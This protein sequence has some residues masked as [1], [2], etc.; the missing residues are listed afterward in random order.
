MRLLMTPFFWIFAA[1]LWV[2]WA[3]GSAVLRD[4]KKIDAEI[5]ELRRKRG[6]G[7]PRKLAGVPD[8]SHRALIGA[9]PA[10]DAAVDRQ[11]HV[12]S[13]F[14]MA[15]ELHSREVTL[16]CIESPSGQRVQI[17]FDAQ[18]T[19]ALLEGVSEMARRVG[20]SPAEPGV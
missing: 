6:G 16:S 17:R 12:R 1:F 14:E 5:D 7:D 3:F 11:I 13:P 4:T 19:H 9:S 15:Y 2:A 20:G 10:T 18:T 8:G